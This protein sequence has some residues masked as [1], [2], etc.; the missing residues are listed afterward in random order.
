MWPSC[1]D[2]HIAGGSIITELLGSLYS[3][4][5]ICKN[6]GKFVKIGLVSPLFS[7]CFQPPWGCSLMIVAVSL[8]N[9]WLPEAWWFNLQGS[10]PWNKC[11]WNTT[12]GTVT[13][14]RKKTK[15]LKNQSA[16][17]NWYIF[18]FWKKTILWHGFQCSPINMCVLWWTQ[19]VQLE[20]EGQEQE[21]LNPLV[22]STF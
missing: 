3:L 7:W 6:Q 11:H 19:K 22:A 14:L 4:T 12:D 2:E 9:H 18:S 17:I 1:A 20:R 5:S 15:I 21:P 10:P 16:I 8:L 13:H